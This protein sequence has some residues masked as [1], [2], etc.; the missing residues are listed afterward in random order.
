MCDVALHVFRWHT[1]DQLLRLPESF[2]FTFSTGVGAIR[3]HD[4]LTIHRQG[5]DMDMVALKYVAPVPPA[6]ATKRSK[7]RASG[8]SGQRDLF[9]GDGGTP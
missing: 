9:A 7:S 3:Q 5:V 8:A 6:K 4:R 1:P 2:P